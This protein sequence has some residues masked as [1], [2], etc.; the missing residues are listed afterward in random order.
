MNAPLP[1]VQFA[2]NLAVAAHIRQQDQQ[3]IADLHR[4]ADA[5]DWNGQVFKRIEEVE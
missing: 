3:R 5:E 4:L 1:L 2:Q